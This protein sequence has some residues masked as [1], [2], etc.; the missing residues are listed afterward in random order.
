[1]NK[2]ITFVIAISLSGITVLSDYFIKKASLE[3]AVWSKW[4]LLGGIIYAF[5]AIGW[6]FVMKNLKLSTI[7]VIYGVSCITLLA[8]VSVFI[9]NE[10]ISQM[11]T[12]GILLGISSIAILYKFA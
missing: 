9:F 12:V 6:F 7:G 4:L 8:I 1:M 3:N 10:K 5:T 2:L 11:E